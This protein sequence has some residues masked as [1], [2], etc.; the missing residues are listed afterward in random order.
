M[1]KTLEMVLFTIALICGCPF[2]VSK[3]VNGQDGL[4][5]MFVMLFIINPIYCVVAGIAAGKDFFNC[6][7][8][9][10][11]IGIV[12]VAG[13]MIIFNTN[14]SGL[15]LYALIYLVITSISMFITYRIEKKRK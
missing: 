15:Y 9:P 14:D 2:I 1:K 7:A 5:M 10:L 13:Y 11:I 12:F 4:A 6:L 3:M 8:Y